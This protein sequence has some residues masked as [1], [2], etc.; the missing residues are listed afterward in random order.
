MVKNNKNKHRQ[1]TIWHTYN[2]RTKWQILYIL[3]QRRTYLES[4]QSSTEAGIVSIT[5]QSQI[6]TWWE[7]NQNI[8]T[9]ILKQRT[10]TSFR[11]KHLFQNNEQALCCEKDVYFIAID[12]SFFL[13]KMPVSKYFI[14]NPCF[15]RI[16]FSLLVSML[17]ANTFPRQKC[18]FKSNEQTLLSAQKI[19]VYMATIEH[20]FCCWK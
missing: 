1:I 5:M 3:Y 15:G 10:N 7:W 4:Y 14:T 16:I 9:P 13:A 19:L 11:K 6:S 20:V 2:K 17:Q 12:T 8:K 18:L